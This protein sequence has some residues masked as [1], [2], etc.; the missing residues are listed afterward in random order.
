MQ[1]ASKPLSLPTPVAVSKPAAKENRH[2]VACDADNHV[3][4]HCYQFCKMSVRERKG[5]AKQKRLCF[6]CLGLAH[7]VFQC[8]SKA[9][10]KT[11][12]Q[13]HDSLLHWDSEFMKLVSTSASSSNSKKA[14]QN[15]K[16]QNYKASCAIKS[17]RRLRIL[18]VRN[19]NTE[20]GKS[21]EILAL[22]DSGADTQ[23]LIAS[24]F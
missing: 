23:S 15:E 4:W 19:S 6:N 20:N 9:R 2:C 16:M 18:T 12:Q 3:I 7:K 8:H 10:S 22:L 1:S 5:L 14:K 21:V 17:R 11:Y 13:S 24:C